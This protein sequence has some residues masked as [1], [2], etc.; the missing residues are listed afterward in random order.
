ME[1]LLWTATVKSPFGITGEV[2]I[3][4]HNDDCSYLGKLKEVVLRAKDGT[5]QRLAIQSFRMQGSQALMKFAGFD[6]PETARALN[7]QHLLVERSKAAPL[8]KGQ[9]YV[10]DLIGCAMVHEGETLAEVVS[11]IDGA[12]AVLLEVRTA[13][14]HLF[15]VPYLK[16]YIGE[17]DLKNRTIEL[18]TPW[19][20]A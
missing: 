17:V 6:D 9:Y 10:A 8:K 4:A 2:K 5:E 1:E 15:M 19:I 7:G 11:S 3:H 13:D 14:E 20:L 16:E 12:Q 18:K